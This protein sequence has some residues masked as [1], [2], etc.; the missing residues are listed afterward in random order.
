MYLKY[1]D[2]RIVS[3]EITS[4]CNAACPQCPRTDNPILPGAELKME[5]IER[6]FPQEFCSQLDLIYM[7]GNYGD[8]MTSNT[9]IGA[10]E[11]LHRMGVPK[12][13]LYTNGSGRNPHW[14]QALAQAMTGENDRVI[15]SIDG[16]ADTNSIYRQNTNWDR[17]MQSV[18]AFIQAGGK[19]VW[20]YLIF[21][22]NQHQVEAARDLAQEL[23]FVEFV[24]KATSRFVAKEI[25]DKES[26]NQ[27]LQQGKNS[28]VDAKSDRPNQ[29]ATTNASA[30]QN[31][32]Q[33]AV[34]LHRQGED[35]LKQGQLSEAIAACQ[36]ALKIQPNFAAACKTLGNAFQAMGK[37]QAAADCYTNALKI[38]PNFPEVYANVGSLYAQ[39]QQWQ[40]AS[41]YYQKAIEL[42]PNFAGAYR[43]LAR[44]LTQLGQPEKANYAWYQAIAIETS[45][46]PAQTQPI[47]S[48][49]ASEE[50]QPPSLEQY[51]NP[52][53]D[54]FIKAVETFGSLN[55]YYR[56]VE[57]S[58]QTQATK[59]IFISFEAELWPCCWVSHTKYAVYNDT[60]RPQML[61]LIEKYG[62]GFNSLRTKSV[63]EAIACDWFREDLTKN[64]SCSKRLDVCAHECGKAFNSTGSQ[65]I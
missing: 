23:G 63:K 7:C 14:W 6:I 60:Y 44:V 52:Q 39:Q 56:N 32:T 65:Y 55:N 29:P 5:D 53:G 3:V 28:Q 61:A 51:K 41:A 43:N 46:A 42:K 38:Q 9:T 13:C 12:I 45:Q 58:C 17:I 59:E 40:P 34:G 8:A 50:L 30:P 2:I 54:Q 47:P 31:Q 19:A 11:Y 36:Q 48:Q 20:H 22:H 35:C 15:F 18:K 26:A 25:Y 4:R 24:P 33:T 16:L 64:F 57:I 49:P 10:I 21:E 1:E 27:Q 37:M 62:N